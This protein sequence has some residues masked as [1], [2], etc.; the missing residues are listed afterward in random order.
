[1]PN[2]MK[3]EISGPQLKILKP[4]LSCYSMTGDMQFITQP[5]RP[6]KACA[7]GNITI[8]VVEFSEDFTITPC[9]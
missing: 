3:P 9:V 8:L 4:R 5:V 6:L 2:P 1:M 7:C